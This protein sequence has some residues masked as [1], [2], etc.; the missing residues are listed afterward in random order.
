[1]NGSI[2][3][4][5]EH[6]S[7][8]LRIASP[9]RTTSKSQKQI[10][11]SYRPVATA[12]KVLIHFLQMVTGSSGFWPL[13]IFILHCS[14]TRALSIS[15]SVYLARWLYHEIFILSSTDIMT[16]TKKQS[17]GAHWESIVFAPLR[18]LSSWWCM[19]PLIKLTYNLRFAVY[20]Y[21]IWRLC[22]FTCAR[23]WRRAEK[24]RVWNN[25][26]TQNSEPNLSRVTWAV[27]TAWRR[28]NALIALQLI[29]IF[30]Q[31]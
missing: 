31:M 5:I 11:R 2:D 24:K 10:N 22:Q 15:L 6:Y 28:H 1:M 23:V 16:S 25:W 17:L 9:Q 21:F 12:H 29:T 18:L 13:S 4:T 3:L 20:L 27:C 7:N 14:R 26:N 8:F 30:T 19:N